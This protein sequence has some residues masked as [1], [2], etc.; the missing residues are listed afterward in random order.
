M[1]FFRKIKMWEESEMAT[2]FWISNV[3]ATNKN[4]KSQRIRVQSFV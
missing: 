3:E 1:L 2:L 4:V